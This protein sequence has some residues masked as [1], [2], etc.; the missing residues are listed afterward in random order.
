MSILL[1]AGRVALRLI[2]TAACVHL[3]HQYG[4]SITATYG[5][6]MLPTINLQGDAVVTSRMYARGRGIG[7]GDVVSFWHP[8]FPGVSACKRVIGMPG[9]FV[10][11]GTPG[12]NSDLMIQIPKGHCWVVGD[13]L[14]ASRDSRIFGPLPLALIRGKLKYRWRRTSPRFKVFG[15]GLQKVEEQA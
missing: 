3:I 14:E 12:G 6:S 15:N 11:K 5:S 4:Y 2:K 10:L 7:V 1:P 8:M 13:N 9:D